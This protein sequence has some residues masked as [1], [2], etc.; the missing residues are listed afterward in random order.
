MLCH[1]TY[2]A[3]AKLP[4]VVIF[5]D[6]KSNRLAVNYTYVQGE[7]KFVV[8]LVVLGHVPII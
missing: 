8:F 2:Q 6:K 7:K 4:H 3:I 5:V 1:I